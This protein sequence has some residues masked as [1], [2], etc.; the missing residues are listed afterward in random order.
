MYDHNI[1]LVLL[2]TVKSRRLEWSGHVAGME[3][4]NANRIL[5][6][7]VG[8]IGKWALG[9]SSGIWEENI[10]MDLMKMWR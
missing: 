1:H 6:L 4:G 10:R 2:K 7:G 3:T 5:M 9:R 8:S